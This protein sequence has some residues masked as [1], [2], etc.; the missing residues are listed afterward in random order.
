MLSLCSKFVWFHLKT[1]PLYRSKI[2]N[3]LTFIWRLLWKIL[4]CS[5]SSTNLIFIDS[6]DVYLTVNLPLL[7]LPNLSFWCLIFTQK[8]PASKQMLYVFCKRT[9]FILTSFFYLFLG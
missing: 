3:D 7:S 2:N 8:L 1:L 4:F 5:V 6:H 9:T